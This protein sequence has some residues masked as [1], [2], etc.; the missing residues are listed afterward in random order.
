MEQIGASSHSVIPAQVR[1]LIELALEEDVAGGDPT[2]EAL[3]LDQ[4]WGSAQVVARAP[5]VLAGT[6]VFAAVFTTLDP[7]LQVDLL[8]ADGS[9]VSPGEL[10]A[11]VS[12]PISSILKGERVAL[13]FL[14]RLSGIATE[15][16]RYVAAVAG[17]PVRIVDTRK[18]APG[19]RWLEKYAVRM[20]GGFNHRLSLSDG[21][22]VKDNHLA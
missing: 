19:M 1:R 16:A 6:W 9:H 11:T 18:T 3:I 20:G 22:L 5:G 12:G 4:E 21:V 13:N 10:L 15:T 7:R 2:T 17:L 14:Q 8:H